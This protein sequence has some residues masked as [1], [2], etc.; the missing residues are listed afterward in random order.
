[1]KKIVCL[2]VVLIFMLCGCMNSS[3]YK[4]SGDWSGLSNYMFAVEVDDFDGDIYEA[5]TYRFYPD[6]VDR[7]DGLMSKETPIVWDIY[8]SDSEYKNVSELSDTEYV[9]S[10]GGIDKIEQDIILSQGQYVYINYNEV[11]GEP[12]GILRFEKK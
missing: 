1:M 12:A 6:L 8:V 5:G 11:F 10:I 4:N 7:I 2:C 9:A 3:K